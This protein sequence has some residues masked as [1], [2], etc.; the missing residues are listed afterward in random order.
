MNEIQN[1]QIYTVGIEISKSFGNTTEDDSL[2]TNCPLCLVFYFSSQSRIMRIAKMLMLSNCVTDNINNT[3][4]LHVFL[5][6]SEFIL[7]ETYP[8]WGFWES[9]IIYFLWC[10]L[11]TGQVLRF[12]LKRAKTARKSRNHSRNIVLKIT[13]RIYTKAELKQCSFWQHY[14][15]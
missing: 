5:L 4:G 3:R 11:S 12:I 7:W 9:D 10:V 1:I 6:G 15:N 13:F 8:D 14:R 2:P